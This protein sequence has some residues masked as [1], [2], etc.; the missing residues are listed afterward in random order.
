VP[1][2]VLGGVIANVRFRELAAQS[3]IA[4]PEPIIPAAYTA[5]TGILDKTL[6]RILCNHCLEAPILHRRSPSIQDFRG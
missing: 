5:M 4:K 2:I 1:K 3:A 6:T